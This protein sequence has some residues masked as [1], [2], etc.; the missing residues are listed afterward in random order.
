MHVCRSS[1][2]SSCNVFRLSFEIAHPLV[3]RLHLRTQLHHISFQTR[4]LPR[5]HLHLLLDSIKSRVPVFHSLIGP[6]VAFAFD[7]SCRGAV[8]P[9]VC[10]TARAQ[11]VADLSTCS[12]RSSKQCFF[13]I[14]RAS[15]TLQTWSSAPGVLNLPRVLCRFLPCPRSRRV[16]SRYRKLQ[17]R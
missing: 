12:R 7:E 5:Q 16:W 15:S 6:T 14:R 3:V 8:L 9:G 10:T 17:R 13:R 2:S 1:G 11:D 4:H